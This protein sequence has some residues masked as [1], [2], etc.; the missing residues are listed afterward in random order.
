MAQIS[1]MKKSHFLLSLVACS[2]ATSMAQATGNEVWNENNRFQ[3]NTNYNGSSAA[4]AAADDYEGRADYNYTTAVMAKSRK[5]AAEKSG[6]YNQQAAYGN[7]GYAAMNQD[8]INLMATIKNS[9]NCY[10]DGNDVVYNINVLYNATPSSYVAIFHINQAGKKVQELDS[11]MQKRVNKFISSA[12]SLGLKKEDF[13]LDM[14][15]LVP[16]FEKEKK[17][18]SKNYTQVPKGFE[19]QKNIHVKYKNPAALDAL[20]TLAAQSEIYDLIK[21]EYQF[22][23]TEIAQ[24]LMRQKAVKVLQTRLNNSKQLGVSVDTCFRTFNER[25]YEFYPIDQYMNYKPMAVS[26][27]DDESSTSAGSLV[28]TPVQRTTVF[29][30]QL[31][32]NGFD[33]VINPS[34]L[35]PTI[36]FVYSLEMRYRLKTPVIV[37]TK[38]EIKKQTDL[39]IITPQGTIKEITK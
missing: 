37:N 16:I 12:L 1:T 33:A 27:I 23:S 29:Y 39:L 19:M 35:Q 34:S 25:N 14:I 10:Y 32:S 4:P 8:K 20:F 15:A 24:N 7:T 28:A 11:L 13:Y 3:N 36:Q 38:T 30:N 31:P 9:T 17:T 26:S 18:F 22:D 2:A 21:V 5:V 6:I